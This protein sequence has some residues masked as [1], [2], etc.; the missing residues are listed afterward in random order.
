MEIRVF[1]VDHFLLANYHLGSRDIS[2]SVSPT[3]KHQVFTK[4][5]Y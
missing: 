4:Q 2:K 3:G 5:I 1:P